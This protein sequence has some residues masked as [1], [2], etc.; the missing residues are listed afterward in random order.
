MNIK[1]RRVG[2]IKSLGYII[3][4]EGRK[5]PVRVGVMLKSLRSGVIGEFLA[6]L[7]TGFISDELDLIIPRRIA[8]KL[9]LWPP[10]KG[11][12]MELLDTVGGEVIAYRIPDSV[13][14]TAIER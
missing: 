6:L 11:S 8:E 3:P 1:R 4:F 10:P 9:N 2:W 7:N 13:E 14:L 12:T 5:L